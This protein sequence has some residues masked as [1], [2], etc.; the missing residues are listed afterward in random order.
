MVGNNYDEIYFTNLATE[1]RNAFNEKF[2]Q[3]E[4]KTYGTGS[5]CSLSLPLYL[6]L[7]PEGDE[8]AVL[9]NLIADI[10]KTEIT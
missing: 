6:G 10:K 1:I 3:E 5:Q 7:T 8:K 9:N 4:K 2:Y